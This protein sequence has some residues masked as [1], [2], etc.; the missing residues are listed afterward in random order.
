MSIAALVTIAFVVWCTYEANQFAFSIFF[1]ETMFD[2]PLGSLY[3]ALLST[4]IGGAWSQKLFT[5]FMPD[6]P[7][8]YVKRSSA[9]MCGFIIGAASNV[10]VDII[11]TYFYAVHCIT[12]LHF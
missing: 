4:L 3:V 5:D 7:W 1:Q 2:S 10:A 8:W 6:S 12:Q 9:L 11:V